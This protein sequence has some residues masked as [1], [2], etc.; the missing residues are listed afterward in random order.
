MVQVQ[1]DAA[2]A[3]GQL[4]Y[5]T[6]ADDSAPHGMTHIPCYYPSPPTLHCCV[7]APIIGLPKPPS[8]T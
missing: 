2:A 8:L 1:T 6:G 3:V 5:E 7:A 4:T